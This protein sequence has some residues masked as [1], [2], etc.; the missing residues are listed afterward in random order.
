MTVHPAGGTWT[1]DICWHVSLK[2]TNVNLVVARK[3]K[4]RG[5]PKSSGCAHEC[6]D[7]ISQQSNEWS[8]RN[9]SQDRHDGSTDATTSGCAA[10]HGWKT[11]IN[12]SGVMTQMQICLVTVGP[13]EPLTDLMS[14]KTMW[15]ICCGLFS[16]QIS[17]VEPLWE[18]LE[19]HIISTTIIKTPNERISF[20]RMVFILAEGLMKCVK[21]RPRS[22]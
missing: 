22:N 1:F 6:L 12:E 3:E 4:L 21:Y 9:F 14:M 17:S 5:S 11:W 2:T 10:K 15:I 7:K 18:T 19:Q 8:L 20:G 13:E 16:H